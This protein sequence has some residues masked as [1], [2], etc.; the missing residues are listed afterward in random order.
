VCFDN[1][2]QYISN[3]DCK[4]NIWVRITYQQLDII[5]NLCIWIYF[6]HILHQLKHYFIVLLII[7]LWIYDI[8]FLIICFIIIYGQL[9][10]DVAI[11][12]A[13]TR[14]SES[15]NI[16]IIIYD[17]F[18]YSEIC[19]VAYIFKVEEIHDIASLQHHADIID[20]DECLLCHDIVIIIYQC[21]RIY[22]WMILVLCSLID[23]C[24]ICCFRWY[25]LNIVHIIYDNYIDPIV[26]QH[27]FDDMLLESKYLV[28]KIWHVFIGRKEFL[29]YLCELFILYCCCQLLCKY[30]MIFIG[31]ILT[32]HQ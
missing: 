2:L 29:Q 8:S 31:Q 17:H 18:I 23:E 20:L 4:T 24:D 6:M 1:I 10:L 26:L 32:W 7:L 9:T 30:L 15:K 27:I 28:S 14:N 12:V 25:R 3:S 5:K 16:F 13:W 22:H 11:F 21:V 19:S